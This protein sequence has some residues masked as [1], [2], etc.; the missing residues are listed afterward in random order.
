MLRM[1]ERT[2]PEIELKYKRTGKRGQRCSS[3]RAQG[4]AAYDVKLQ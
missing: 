2:V 3:P 4:A 1:A